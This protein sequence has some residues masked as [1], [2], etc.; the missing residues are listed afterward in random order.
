M[1]SEETKTCRHLA[2]DCNMR[3]SYKD[4]LQSRK[5]FDESVLDY[6]QFVESMTAD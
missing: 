3:A 6:D 1:D 2:C 5:P 4:Y